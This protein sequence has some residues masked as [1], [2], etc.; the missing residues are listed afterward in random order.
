MASVV[1]MPC[2]GLVVGG[3]SG[4]DSGNNKTSPLMSSTR[5]T[6]L[7]GLDADGGKLWEQAFREGNLEALR[8]TADGGFILSGD[9]F[10]GS[11]L[12]DAWVAKLGARPDGDSDG[13]GV[14]DSR[15]RCPN[16]PPGAVV[17][18]DG[19][20]IRQLCPCD[21]DWSNHGDY[22]RR[23][24]EVVWSFYHE[25]LITAGE[26]RALIREAAR[27]DCGKRDPPQLL[28]QPQDHHDV[29]RVGLVLVLTHEAD[30]RCVLECS[31]DGQAWEAI[32]TFDGPVTEI[33]VDGPT[34]DGAGRCFY[35][36]RFGP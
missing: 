4:S 20:S 1:L 30:G 26:R 32:R 17:N 6:W 24:L 2:G 21:G 8:P 31:E 22:V 15:D 13:D 23:M 34:R 29:L 12:I 16:T 19:C 28:L 3:S 14:P 9:F 18:S 36:M 35:R 25:G 27:S 11:T 7:L 10:A 5:D 33:T